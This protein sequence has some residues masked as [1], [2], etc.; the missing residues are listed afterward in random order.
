MTVKLSD[1]ARELRNA[2]MREWRR[3]NKDKV[4]KSV[5]DH[6]ERKAAELKEQQSK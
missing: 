3:K 1:E 2:Y 4:R 6:W 5:A